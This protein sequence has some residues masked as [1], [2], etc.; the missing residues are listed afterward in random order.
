MN[1]EKQDGRN[2]RWLK[3]FGGAGLGI[4]LAMPSAW[5]VGFKSYYPYTLDTAMPSGVEAQSLVTNL[6]WIMRPFRS[7]HQQAMQR[8][9]NS[10]APPTS[11]TGHSSIEFISI[12]ESN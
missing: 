8:S 7:A 10:V 2:Y 1:Y 4:F 12:A 11:E 6:P 9:W 5:A 3:R